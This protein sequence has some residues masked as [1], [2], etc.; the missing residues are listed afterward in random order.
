M[1][2]D[3]IYPLLPLRDIVVYPYMVVPLFVGRD[4][5]K[6]A[7]DYAI[8]EKSLVFLVTQKN[9]QVNEPSEKDLHQV[10]TIG[11]VIQLIRMPDGTAKVLIE[12]LRRARITNVV[13]KDPYFSAQIEEIEEEK[14]KTAEGEALIRS[15]RECFETYIKLN[16]NIPPEVLLTVSNIDDPVQFAFMVVAQ[17]NLKLSDRQTL[18]EVDGVKNRLERVLELIQ[19]EIEILEVERKIRTRV[20]RQMEKNQREYY[21]NEQMQAI[22][23]ELGERDEFKADIQELEKRINEKSLSA[24]ARKKAKSELRKLKMMSPMSAEATVTRNYLDWLLGLPW[25]GE[26]DSS[27]IDVAYAESVLNN[28]HYGLEKIKQRFLEHLAIMHLSERA[29]SPILCLVGP[30]G[31][32][33]TSLAKSIARALKRKFMRISLGGVRDEAEIRGHR[34][35][36]IG[37][38]PGRLIQSMKKAG[39]MN[40]VLLLDEIDKMAQDFRGDPSS[41]LLEVLDPEQNAAFSDHFLEVGYDL[42]KVIFIATANQLGP[43][44]RPLL[45]RMELI[46]LNS[47]TEVEKLQIA[48]KHLVA[49]QMKA[50]GL[51]TNQVTFSDA[52]LKD[53]ILYFTRESGVRDLER[54]IASA[55][56]KSATQ[57]VRSKEKVKSVRVTNTQ[58]KKYFGAAKFRHGRIEK[59]SQ[60]GIVSGL[61]W[62]ELGGALLTV[63]AIAMPGTGKLTITGQLGEVMQESAQAALSYVRANSKPFQMDPNFYKKLDIHIHVPE[64]AIPKDGPSAGITM[65]SAIVSAIL[66]YPIHAEVAMTGEITLSGQVLPIGGLREKLMAAI[67]GGIRKVLI[68]YENESS[69]QEVPKQITSKLVIVPIKQFNQVLDEC[70]KVPKG[71]QILLSKKS[72]RNTHAK[73]LDV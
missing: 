42:S 5:S 57:I 39:T 18:L 37:A 33:K 73:E 23:K 49:K 62:T 56:R 47:Y 19:A 9:P 35:T 63:E 41:A 2:K 3:E 34:R 6:A 44:P 60:I 68:P 61:A 21:L 53:M 31:V 66:K 17:I 27:L 71:Q 26:E 38:M 46:E 72:T 55:I 64:G 24:E 20:K 28:E 10:G 14:L 52:A 67:R 43:V 8:E 50:H 32:G 22:Q 25:H 11:S 16:K 45:D 36:Y 12:G 69:L 65:A 70:L 7:L 4:K 30:P 1:A 13:S 51:K 40:P 54:L 15:I 29:R 58:V 59:E 48:K